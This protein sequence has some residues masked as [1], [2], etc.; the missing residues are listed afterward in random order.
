MGSGDGMRQSRRVQ[1]VTVAAGG[2]GSRD[3]DV[4][5]RRAKQDPSLE[6][7]MAP[8]RHQGTLAIIAK[9]AKIYKI[10]IMEN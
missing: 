6:K 10:Q 3:E 9:I 4:G 7:D 8:R 5:V 1:K 2:G